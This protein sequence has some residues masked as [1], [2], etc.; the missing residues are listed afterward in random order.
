[1]EKILQTIKSQKTEVLKEIAV[2]LSNKYEDAETLVFDKT[3]EELEKRLNEKEFLEF[4]ET[5]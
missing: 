3:L 5:L 1:M 4:C 2:E